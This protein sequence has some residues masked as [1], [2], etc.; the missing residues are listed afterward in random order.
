MDLIVVNFLV[1]AFDFSSPRGV[2]PI[3]RWYTSNDYLYQRL[4]LV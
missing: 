4:S 1:A 3:F 2:Y